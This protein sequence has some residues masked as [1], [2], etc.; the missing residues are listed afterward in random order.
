[1]RGRRG[2]GK[3]R[4]RRTKEEEYRGGPRTT[5]YS[6]VPDLSEEMIKRWKRERQGM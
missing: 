5:R 2:R 4:L 3:R 1:L 6:D